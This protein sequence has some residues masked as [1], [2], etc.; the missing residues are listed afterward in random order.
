MMGFS[1]EDVS[2]RLHLSST[3]II[4]KWERGKVMPSAENLLKLSVLYK[5]LANELYYELTTI[6]GKELFPS[7]S[8]TLTKRQQRH[9]D[10]GP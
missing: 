6:Y 7:D 3:S 5:T 10:R 2:R 9:T 1:Q 8:G 4:S